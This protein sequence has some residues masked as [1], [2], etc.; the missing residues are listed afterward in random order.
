MANDI[1]HF[2]SVFELFLPWA[3]Y[4][5]CYPIYWLDD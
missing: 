4:S 3:V 1:K 2:P 5:V